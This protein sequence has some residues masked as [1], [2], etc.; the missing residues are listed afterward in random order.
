MFFKKSCNMFQQ[1]NLYWLI[2]SEHEVFVSSL[3]LECDNVYSKSWIFSLY[4]RRHIFTGLH[5][6]FYCF[7]KNDPHFNT[8]K[9]STTHLTIAW[10]GVRQ[11]LLQ[12]ESR[13]IITAQRGKNI[14]IMEIM[15]TKIFQ[16][17]YRLGT[18]LICFLMK[19]TTNKQT[20]R[21][22]GIML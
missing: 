3:L 9:K 1:R 8:H 21:P 15:H 20:N 7:Q 14:G 16:A 4:V 6:V 11:C 19:K 17:W 10:H 18:N 2:K 5:A 12:T 22:T 13:Q